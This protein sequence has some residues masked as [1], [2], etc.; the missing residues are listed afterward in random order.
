MLVY[1]MV[2]IDYDAEMITIHME[3]LCGISCSSG[4]VGA[5]GGGGGC[6][7]GKMVT[8]ALWRQMYVPGLL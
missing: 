2:V 6:I 3:V 5:P 4:T 8:R 7:K 1:T